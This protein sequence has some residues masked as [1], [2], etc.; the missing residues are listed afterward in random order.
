MLANSNQLLMDFTVGADQVDTHK[1]SVLAFVA[2]VVRATRMAGHQVSTVVAVWLGQVRGGAGVVEP[3]QPAPDLLALGW[4]ESN[5]CRSSSCS[6]GGAD[7]VGRLAG[8]E[9]SA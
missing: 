3:P 4:R 1:P 2:A 9:H 5:S 8:G 7:L 6:P